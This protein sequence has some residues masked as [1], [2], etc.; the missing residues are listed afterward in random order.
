LLVIS[1]LDLPSPPSPPF[2]PLALHALDARSEPD[3]SRTSPL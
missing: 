1:C 3:G 2:G